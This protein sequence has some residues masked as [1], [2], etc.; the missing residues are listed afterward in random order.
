MARSAAAE[1][2]RPCPCGL[3]GPQSSK[4]HHSRL[5]ILSES[6]V[7][8][9]G[10]EALGAQEHQGKDFEALSSGDSVSPAGQH[11]NPRAPRRKCAILRSVSGALEAVGSWRTSKLR[12]RKGC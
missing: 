2:H 3:W 12:E 8:T 4:A 6:E 10:P 1:Q 5:S 9:K 11:S 7:I